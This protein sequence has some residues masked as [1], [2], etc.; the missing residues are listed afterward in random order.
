MHLPK[1]AKTVEIVPFWDKVLALLFT[2]ALTNEY[3]IKGINLTNSETNPKVCNEMLSSADMGSDAEEEMMTVCLDI[4]A[5]MHLTHLPIIPAIT[6]QDV[7]LLPGET[8]ATID[9]W[10]QSPGQQIF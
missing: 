6:H 1:N 7:L 10:M 4:L 2:Q 5:V 8:I 3:L 9:K